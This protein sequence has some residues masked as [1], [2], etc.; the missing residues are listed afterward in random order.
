MYL[1]TYLLTDL[2]IWKITKNGNLKNKELG[3]DWIYGNDKWEL[4]PD[5][6]YFY[7][8]KQNPTNQGGKYFTIRSFSHSQ[9]THDAL[10][11][12]NK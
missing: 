5:D 12:N 6:R 10:L 8:A 11:I 7:L 3:Q 2:Q 9:N 4:L 1:L